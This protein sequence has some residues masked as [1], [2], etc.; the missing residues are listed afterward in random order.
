MDVGGWNI[1]LTNSWSDMVPTVSEIK[2][3]VSVGR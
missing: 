2:E 1:A 3:K